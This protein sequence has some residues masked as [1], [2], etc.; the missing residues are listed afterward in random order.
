MENHHVFN[1]NPTASRALA[2]ASAGGDQDALARHLHA[3]FGADGLTVQQAQSALEQLYAYCGFPRSLNAL[4]T[5]MNVVEERKES[6]NPPHEG[7]PPSPLP[8]G[9]M[10]ERGR[11]LRE[12]LVGHPVGGALA[13]FAPR[14]DYYL[15]AHLFGDIFSDDRLTHQE[16]ETITIAALGSDLINCQKA[17]NL[18]SCAQG[19]RHEPSFL[20]FCRTTRT[21]QALLP[22]F[23]W[24][25]AGR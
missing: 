1:E 11:I 9:D 17:E 18:V 19:G 21:Y 20:P 25:S 12:E 2:A 15:T 3:A 14:S 5:L 13:A 7:Q 6:G 24:Y 8:A 10:A 4:T 22:T 16:R 23:T